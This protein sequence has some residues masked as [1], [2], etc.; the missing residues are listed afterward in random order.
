[1]VA[2]PGV[3]LARACDIWAGIPLLF[4]PGTEWNYSVATDVLGRV[5]EVVSGQRLEEFFTARILR[6]LGMTDTGFYAGGTQCP[7]SPPSTGRARRH[8]GQA[9]CPGR[10]ARE[11]RPCSAGAAAWFTAADY[12]RFT[13]MLLRCTDSPAGELDGTGC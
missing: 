2:P 7:G 1:M 8:G 9:R 5:I 3:D 11:R 12:H 10:A 13:Q 6:P 4:Q